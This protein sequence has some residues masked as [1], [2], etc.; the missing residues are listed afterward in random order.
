MGSTIFF[1]FFP[2]LWLLITK[3]LPPKAVAVAV[4]VE[5]RGRQ[6]SISSGS[7]PVVDNWGLS[8]AVHH[9]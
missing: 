5:N 1:S 3:M 8:T 7:R 4:L 2:I 9:Q 6:L